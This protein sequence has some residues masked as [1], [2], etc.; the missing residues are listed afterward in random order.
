M[1]GICGEYRRAGSAPVEV[2]TLRAMQKA[3][4]HRGPSDEGQ[5]IGA[6][7]GLGFRR[8]SIIDLEG[9]HQPLANEDETVW[10]TLNGE[11]YN[12]QELRAEL[13]EQGHQFRT[14]SD[15]EVI[16]H[17]YE[18]HGLAFCGLL[19]GMF[20]IALYDINRDRLVL[21]RDRY[22]IKPVYYWSSPECLV[23]G[24]EIK[25]LL[26][27]PAVSATP[28]EEAIFQ[29]LLLRHSLQ[30]DTLFEQIQKLPAGAFL[31]AE[32][33]NMRIEPFWQPR[34][35]D[36]LEADDSL[37]GK[38]YGRALEDAVTSHIVA[39]VPVGMF[40]SG[41]LDSSVVAALAQ[42]QSA[43][44]LLCFTAGFRVGADETSH[45][46]EVARWIGAEH[47]PIAIEAPEPEILEQLVWHLDEPVADPACLPTFLLAQA[48]ARKVRVVL[49]GEG[50]DETNGGYAKF[51]RYHLFRKH[52]FLMSSAQALWPLLRR[53]PPT[54]ARLGHYEP[55]WR[56][57]DE[58]GAVLAGDGVTETD[59]LAQLCPG[60]ERH[61]TAVLARLRAEWHGC[62]AVDAVQQRL[63]Y[64]RRVFM[65]EDLLMKVD[66]MTMAH[67]LEARVPFLDNAAQEAAARISPEVLFRRGQ[68]KAV[69]RQLAT[70]LLPA[71][72]TQRPQHGFIVPLDRWFAGDFPAYVANLLGPGGLGRRGLV[73]ADALAKVVAAFRQD[74]SQSRQIWSLSLLE[75]WYRHF[76]D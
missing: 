58:A 76:I 21:A 65:R 38:S 13:E 35:P 32:G 57:G 66:R 24:S 19:R 53:L 47:H 68:T 46:A 34:A 59:D 45:A 50:S 2:A 30:P 10:V 36:R 37:A 49:T 12:F 5:W 14:R 29:Y 27:H 7:C 69:L 20:G 54:A 72:I 61:R 48:A 40:L 52:R 11:I 28:N 64:A 16:V 39:D 33:A 1:C 55:L 18:Q 8:L 44:P 22:G 4:R 56:A 63:E 60:L 74:G 62:A 70:N 43:Q 3:I 25:A 6:R 75:I 26:R 9:G 67:G 17:L 73:D 42:R 31:V 51:L 71:A 41:G 15:T 23:Y